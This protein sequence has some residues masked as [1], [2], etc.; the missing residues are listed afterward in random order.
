MTVMGKRRDL[1]ETRHNDLVEESPEKVPR[2][3]LASARS[4]DYGKIKSITR[5]TLTPSLN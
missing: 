3:D 4:S 1:T 2:K 5:I